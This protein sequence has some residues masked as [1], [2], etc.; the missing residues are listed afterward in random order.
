MMTDDEKVIAIAQS[1]GWTDCK[2]RD[3][4]G[5]PPIGIPPNSKDG[6]HWIIPDYLNDANAMQGAMRTLT[7][8]QQME[9]GEGL[10]GALGH[11]ED[12]YEGWTINPDAFWE[13]ATA[14]VK[15][16]ADQFLKTKKLWKP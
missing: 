10:A 16:W 8:A 15:V 1:Q 4:Y 9:F 7:S 11:S 14:P 6:H 13:A 12:Y 5:V 2:P 3:Q